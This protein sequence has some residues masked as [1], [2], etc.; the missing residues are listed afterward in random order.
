[1]ELN[2]H[3]YRVMPFDDAR[4]DSY[5]HRRVEVAEVT[6][7]EAEAAVEDANAKQLQARL[8][9]QRQLAAIEAAVQANFPGSNVHVQCHVLGSL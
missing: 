9:A 3:G 6:A 5:P 8:S 4:V 7:D 2:Q 1:M